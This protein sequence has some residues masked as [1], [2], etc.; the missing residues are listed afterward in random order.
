MNTITWP[1]SLNLHNKYDPDDEQRYR[2]QR[3]YCLLMKL[4]KRFYEKHWPGSW[5][6]LRHRFKIYDLC[7]PGGFQIDDT[8]SP[9]LEQ[10]VI[11]EAP[12]SPYY[13]LR[14]QPLDS[15]FSYADFLTA[16]LPKAMPIQLNFGG[17]LEGETTRNWCTPKFAICVN[18]HAFM[19]FG[20]HNTAHF[21]MISYHQM[22]SGKQKRFVAFGSDEIDPYTGTRHSSSYDVGKLREEY[23]RP[24]VGIDRYAK[25]VYLAGVTLADK[26][27]K[28]IERIIQH[29]VQLE[30]LTSAAE[31][32]GNLA[33]VRPDRI[34]FLRE[35][36]D[37]MWDR[38]KTELRYW[39]SNDNAINFCALAL[40]VSLIHP[41][42]ARELLCE[43]WFSLF[44]QS[45]TEKVLG[46][47]RN[48]GWRLAAE[49]G[50]TM[51]FYLPC[52][53]D[54]KAFAGAVWHKGTRNLLPQFKR[55]GWHIHDLARLRLIFPH[56]FPEVLPK[57]DDFQYVLRRFLREYK[58]KREE[59]KKQDDTLAFRFSLNSILE[60][61]AHLKIVTAKEVAI[62]PESLELQ[63]VS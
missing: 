13:E 2:M 41:R 4:V 11:C 55:I 21:G 29:N 48:E 8:Y 3:R 43:E 53:L 33:I 46:F 12:V 19:H 30:S 1:Y 39:I 42:K 51:R 47:N 27:I 60:Q 56:R 35:Q 38:V 6:K 14:G 15:F 9:A 25:S 24:L 34:W 61:I 22:W 54:E 7:V 17:N 44:L 37:W 31:N 20:T 45:Q 16:P 59:D 50:A 40:G 10:C 18:G 28:E 63:I 36:I 49:I 52:L 32:G 57:E 62:H 58:Q 5:C 26:E 23:S